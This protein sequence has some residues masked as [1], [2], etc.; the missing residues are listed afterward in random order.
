[1]I[2]HKYNPQTFEQFIGQTQ[3]IEELK[4]QTKASL[5]K[6]SAMEHI[7]MGGP[8]GLG[9]TT[10]ARI[11][12][13]ERGVNIVELTGAAI[14]SK[15]SLEYTVIMLEENDI[16]FID[17]IHNLK[18][19]L[20]EML[21]TPLESFVHN[22]LEIE[23]FTL[24]GSTNYV[25]NIDKP[26]RDRMTHQFTF[27]PYTQEAISLI[28]QANGAPKE[29]ADEIAKRARG[30]P[31]VARDLLRKIDN[32]RIFEGDKILEIKHCEE[33]FASLGIDNIGL[34][35][36]DR[37]VLE[38][39]KRNG[40]ND[41]TRAI[42]EKTFSLS[43]GIESYDLCNVIEPYLLSKRFIMRTNRGRTITR[44]GLE[45]LKD[46]EKKNEA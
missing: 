28:V 45:Y 8:P 33:E 3:I 44:Q 23:P 43:L 30:V 32:R 36:Q 7:L 34:T 38:F 15:L 12:A 26:L 22:G 13:K 27:E 19:H 25:G 6:G 46:M 16:L 9:K 37:S 11:I 5:I 2:Y 20:C 21:Y 1:M 39:L 18:P 14:K 4:I 10:L 29:I 35:K 31:R 24:I 41:I 42:G 17:E 40:A